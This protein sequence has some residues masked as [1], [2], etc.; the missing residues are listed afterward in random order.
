VKT[1]GASIHRQVTQCVISDQTD[2]KWQSSV[3][4][5]ALIAISGVNVHAR[6]CR[7]CGYEF[8]PRPEAAR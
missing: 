2:S 6:V 1:S 4:D 8:Y 3:S 7:P 5:R